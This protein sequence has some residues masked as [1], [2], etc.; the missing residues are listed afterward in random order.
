MGSL[1][2]GETEIWDRTPQPK[3]EIIANWS[4]SVC[5]VLA[6]GEYKVTNEE[7]LI[8]LLSLV[9]YYRYYIIIT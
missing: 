5:P 7:R 6:S 4:Q 2:P 3:H 9:R 8:G 1:T